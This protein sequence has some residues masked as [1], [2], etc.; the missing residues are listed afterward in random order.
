MKGSNIVISALMASP[1]WEHVYKAEG[2]MQ[3]LYAQKPGNCQFSPIVLHNRIFY[4][5]VDL[6]IILR[7]SLRMHYMV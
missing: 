4:E 7:L 2:T 6:G 3:Q 5:F 1:Q